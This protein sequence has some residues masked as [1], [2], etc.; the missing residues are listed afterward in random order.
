MIEPVPIERLT[1]ERRRELTRTALVEAAAEVFARRGFHAASL[2]EIADLAGFT[3]GAI[4][5]NFRSKEDL[6]LAVADRV[7]RTHIEAV[8][9]AQEQ[10]A[11]PEARRTGAAAAAVWRDVISADPNLV[12][13]TLEFQLYALRNPAF[14]ERL[15]ALDRQQIARIANLIERE[16]AAFG[17]KLKLPAV[18]LADLMNATAIGL[19]QKAG[20]DAENAER[21]SRLA[22]QFFQLMADAIVDRDD[23]QAAG[24]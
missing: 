18:D 13:L 11:D 3:R 23:P 22:E 4:Y 15:A 5:S 9:A 6:L 14:R 20:V 8:T 2:E 12:P 24:P 7:N 10:A 17:I 19:S 1:P 16:A 21:Y